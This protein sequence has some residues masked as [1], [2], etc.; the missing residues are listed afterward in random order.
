MSGVT[1]DQHNFPKFNL[2]LC[3]GCGACVAGC[4]ENALEMKTNYP[5]YKQSGHCSYCTDCERLC[6]TGAIRA[7]FRFRWA[8][9]A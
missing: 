3:T 5:R 4:P 6:P 1:V 9:G 7:P 8:T 2:D